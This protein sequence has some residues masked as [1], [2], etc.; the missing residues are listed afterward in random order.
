M[1]RNPGAPLGHLMADFLE[2]EAAIDPKD[3]DKTCDNSY[4]KLQPLCRIG[5]LRQRRKALPETTA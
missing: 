4:C 3:D 1:A 2:G 5:E